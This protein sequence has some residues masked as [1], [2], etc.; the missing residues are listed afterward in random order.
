MFWVEGMMNKRLKQARVE[1]FR[2]ELSNLCKRH[3]LSITSGDSVLE[4]WPF[5]ESHDRDLEYAVDMTDL[6]PE[7]VAQCNL[8]PE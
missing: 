2:A 3:G 4:I 1:R 7:A 5:Q 6:E 8:I